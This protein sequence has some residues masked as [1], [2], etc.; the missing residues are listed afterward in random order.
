M[1]FTEH[2]SD[3]L[4]NLTNRTLVQAL[5]EISDRY[6]YFFLQTG[7]TFKIPN[8]D[9]HSNQSLV[10]LGEIILKWEQL[11][12]E[13]RTSGVGLSAHDEQLA[14]LHRLRMENP[15]IQVRFKL[16]SELGDEYPY[17]AGEISEVVLDLTYQT[18]SG[19]IIVGESDI[20][21]FLRL[22]TSTVR[23]SHD[24]EDSDSQY[25]EL[26]ASGDI[27]KLIVVEMK[28]SQC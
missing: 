22:D 17:Y 7:N 16:P 26:L 12:R 1:K 21:D 2:K 10:M 15:G 3:E 20:K 19:M 18:R 23:E 4:L 25:N 13:Q 24:A 27:K 14:L 8:H 11:K 28:E 9:G 5:D 6:H